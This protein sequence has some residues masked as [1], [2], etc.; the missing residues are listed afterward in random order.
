VLD[1]GSYRILGRS[2]VDIIKTG[3]YKVSALEIEEELRTHPSIAECAVVGVEDPDWGERICAAVEL[4]EDAT[5]SSEELQRWARETLGRNRNRVFGVGPD[6]RLDARA[7]ITWF[8]LAPELR[9][10]FWIAVTGSGPIDVLGSRPIA[11]SREVHGGI[12]VRF[13]EGTARSARAPSTSASPASG[14]SGCA[15]MTAIPEIA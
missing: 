1:G 4:V 5:L 9:P 15:R 12:A 13:A 8:H 10:I 11:E 14:D 2:N 7:S 6:G 3:G